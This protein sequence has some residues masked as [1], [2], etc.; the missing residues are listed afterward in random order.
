[1]DARIHVYSVNGVVDAFGEFHYGGHA[2]IRAYTHVS[3]RSV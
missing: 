1:M 3:A 2:R